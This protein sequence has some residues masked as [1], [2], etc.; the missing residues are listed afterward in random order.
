MRF[1]VYYLLFVVISFFGTAFH[2]ENALLWCTNECNDIRY[3]SLFTEWLFKVLNS[4][5]CENSGVFIKEGKK[6]FPFVLLFSYLMAC[7]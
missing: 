2:L 3:N 4:N 6:F 7:I 1:K 5:L